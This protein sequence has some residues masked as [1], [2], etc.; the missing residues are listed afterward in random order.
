M[1]SFANYLKENAQ[2]EAPRMTVPELE[3]VIAAIT[4]QM[5]QK[6]LYAIWN[7]ASACSGHAIKQQV[8]RGD[9]H[10]LTADEL[11]TDAMDTALQHIAQREEIIWVRE[12]YIKELAK[13]REAIAQS[14]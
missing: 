2:K 4:A 9:E 1:A 11:I 3:G 6:S 14:T 5:D 8:R 13:R 7:M 10:V 12:I